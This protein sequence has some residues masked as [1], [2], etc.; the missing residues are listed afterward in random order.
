MKE[1]ELLGLAK[2]SSATAG[3]DDLLVI[4]DSMNL[5]N[6]DNGKS[7]PSGANLNLGGANMEQVV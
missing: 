4:P 3:I 5:M 1:I 7:G 2:L 6:N